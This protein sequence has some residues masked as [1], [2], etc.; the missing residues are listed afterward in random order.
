VGAVL[1]SE[2][3][4]RAWSF[5]PLVLGSALV[6]IGF[7][8]HG[9][10]RLHRRRADLAPW[11]RIPLFVGG[12]TVTVLAIV[13]PID[14]I[15]E[16]Y[17]QSVHMLQH[18]LIADLGIALTVVAVRGPLV[19]FLLPRDLLVPLARVDRLRRWLRFLLRPGVSYGVWVVALVSWHVP[20][21][22]EAA[23]HHTA[24]HDLMHVSF[25]VGGLLVWTQIVDP[26]RHRRLTLGERVGY[27][28]LVFCTGQILAY[29]ILFDFRPLFSTYV[30]QPVRLLGVSPLTDQKLAGFVMMVEQV[31]TVG[32]A[33]VVLLLAAR[34]ER[35]RPGVPVA[36]QPVT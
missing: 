17:L 6:A 12:V 8:L 7:F 31:F 9:W 10:L 2:T 16:R 19:V 1:A 34:R 25:V 24:V 33:F 35:E 28:A 3:L 22:Y 11:T 4:W 36:H 20:A 15:G 26:A 23:L 13:S 30:D 29:V 32:V 21:F 5:Q 14:A 18:V 27:T